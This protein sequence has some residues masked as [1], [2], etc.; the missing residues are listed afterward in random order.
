MKNLVTIAYFILFLSCTVLAQT[1]NL[2]QIPAVKEGLREQ[3]S[4]SDFELFRFREKSGEISNEISIIYSTAAADALVNNNNGTSGT[5][6]FTQS[7]TAILGWG[8]NV[9]IGFNDS[10]SYTGGANKF[11]GWSYSSDGGAS[12]VDGGT[13]PTSSIG[14]AGDPV[15]ARNETTGRIYLSTLGFSGSG[16]IQMFR[17]DDNGMT[18][19]APVNATPGGSSED[20]Q[21]HTVDNYSGTGNGN[22]YMIS[23]RFGGSPGIYFFRSTD[24]GSSFTPS[25]GVNIFS[26]GQGAF[27]AVG[28]DHSV[29]AF[30]YNSSTS[31]LVRKSTDF[32]VSFGAAVTIFSG[33]SGGVNGDLGLT[34]KRNGLTTFSSFRSNAFPHVAINPVSGHIYTTFNNNPAGTD[35][36]DVYLTISTDGG[37]T[38]ST[39]T[40]VNDDATTTDQWQPT[41]AVTPNGNRL[42]IFYYSR[43]EDTAENNLFKYY[44]RLGVI[45]GSTVNFDPSFAISDV[46]SLPEFG[47]DNVVNSVYMGDYNHAYATNDAIHV[48]WS[49]NRDDLAGGAPRKDPNVYYEKITLGPPCPI[50]PPSNPSP[51]NGTSGLPLTGN[52]IAWTNGAGANLIEV[53]FGVGANI[54]KVYDG[55]PITSL[56]L[57]SFEP[58]SYNTTYGWQVRGKND[59]CTVSGPLWSFSTMQ[60]PNLFQWCEPFDNLS[61]WTILGPLGTTNWSANSSSN[62]GGNPPELRMTWTPSF[63]GVSK[64]RSSAINLPNNQ[65]VNYSFKFYLDWYA[66]PS[67]IITVA[68]TYDGGATSTP[69]YTENNPTGNIGPSIV[70]G[71]FTTPSSGSANTQIEI[72]YDGYSFNIDNIYWDDICFSYIVPVELTS[73]A[74]STNGDEVALSWTTATET[75]NQGFQ[76]ERMT[77]GG[78]FEQIGYVAGFGTTTEPKA[79]SFVDTKLEE[80]SYTYRL[81]QMDYDGTYTYSSEVSVEVELPL[82]YSLDQNYPNPFNPSTTIKYAIAED[83]YVKLAVYNMLGEEVAMIVNSVQKAGRYE[84][85]FNATG[86]SSGVY[87]YRIETASFTSSKKLMLMK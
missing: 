57:A 61:N 64:I 7:E 34:G 68:I 27:V 51:A 15:L 46:A 77:A 74:A 4:E 80:G 87:V 44:A 82:E 35:K 5:A 73:F 10:G 43:Q 17:S 30:Y 18:W 8:N 52:S 6:N 76:I 55:P 13:L 21:W 37:A 33:I 26:G 47:R 63:T 36:A 29:Y 70:N 9:V 84:V 45:S 49:D 20:K 86:L 28:P 24:H 14:D 23:R 78:S 19:M 31:I 66:D 62:A 11:T 83:G 42:G 25:G 40:R 39:P 1:A 59:S 2:E 65:L 56:S 41:I 58:L 72:T 3:Y 53:W 48:V 54:N 71:T 75:N 12:F 67:G 50:D 69:I 38:W 79:Y 16:T 81:K 60:D 32:G 85:N 22:V